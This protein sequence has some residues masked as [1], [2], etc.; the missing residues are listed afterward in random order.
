MCVDRC[1]LVAA[2]LAVFGSL[3]YYLLAIISL[4][5]GLGVSE[6]LAAQGMRDEVSKSVYAI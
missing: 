3:F 4:D 1:Y 6:K 2:Y 5:R